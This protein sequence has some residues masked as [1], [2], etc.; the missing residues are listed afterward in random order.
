MA[1]DV[2]SLTAQLNAALAKVQSDITSV[3]SVTG[4]SVD[5]LAG[6]S[7]DI[8]A[9]QALAQQVLDYWDTQ[10]NVVGAPANFASGTP[11][12]AM[13]A[14]VAAL[15]QASAAICFAFDCVNKLGRLAKNVAAVQN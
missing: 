2:T 5:Q 1:V 6:L 13:I 4:A 3:P 15:Q 9:V 7:T 14:N 8:A 11:P 10:M 12:A